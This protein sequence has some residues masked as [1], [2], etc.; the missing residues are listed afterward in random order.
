MKEIVNVFV[1]QAGV[2]LGSAVW[3][4][5][6]LEHGVMPNGIHA[7]G[8]GGRGI[9][10][11][12]CP[13]SNGQMVPRAVFVDLE[14]TPID[15]IRTGAYR[16]LFNSEYMLTGK[17]DAASNFARGYY[18]VGNELSQICLDRIRRAAEACER[19]QGFFFFR[20]FGGGT[21]SGF[22]ANV[23][24][25][26][27]RDY[28]KISILEFGVYPSPRVSCLIVEPYNAVLTTHST[29]N[30]MDVSFLFDNEALYDICARNLD[31]NSPTYTNLNR[32][33]AQVTSAITAS[34]RFEGS[35][36][37]DLIEFQTNLVPYPRIHFPLVTYAP[38]LPTNKAAY[39]N[40][41]TSSLVSSCFEPANQ[42][43]RCD[44]RQ[45]KYMACCLL[46]R[47][48]VSPNDVNESVARM[49]SYKTIQFVDFSPTGFKVGI[50]YMPPAY[51]PGGDLARTTRALAMLS[52]TSAI[53]PAWS[54]LNSKFAL[55]F[56]KRAF[57]HHYVGEGMEESEFTEAQEDLKA[58]EQDYS[59]TVQ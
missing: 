17:E 41:T 28:G 19:P 47:G 30:N 44:P 2:Q 11:M 40:V 31:V 8:G 50:N 36:N 38:I 49:K 43:I 5:Y 12:F 46:F 53:T 25:K 1:G 24:D 16:R 10:T 4:L 55:M 23:L 26:M 39:E 52:N 13:I 54:R 14:P 18:S 56:R 20:S 57:V 29:L 9:T 58:L 51:V 6:C 21:G 22:Q 27:R 42:M 33:M 48:D 34:I 3:E 7:A 15:E 37:V 32:L 45:G 35:L 59:G